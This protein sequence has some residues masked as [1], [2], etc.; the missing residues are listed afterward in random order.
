MI[1]VNPLGRYS[2]YLIIWRSFFS[3]KLISTFKWSFRSVFFSWYI[4]IKFPL[5]A[6]LNSKNSENP[7]ISNYIFRSKY[8]F[9]FYILNK[10]HPFSDLE[11]YNF[12]CNF[13]AKSYEIF[14]KRFLNWISEVSLFEFKWWIFRHLFI[15]L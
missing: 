9:I 15:S 5:I 8:F 13:F 6:W 10:I 2:F 3:W 1:V 14:E 4:F 12:L 7:F 11:T